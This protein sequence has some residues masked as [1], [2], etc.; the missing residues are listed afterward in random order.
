MLT[1]GDY[2][3][4]NCF[5]IEKGK[6][7]EYIIHTKNLL[8]FISLL[9]VIII[10][11]HLKNILLKR[12]NARYYSCINDYEHIIN[13]QGMKNHEYN[14]QLLVLKG[15]FDNKEKFNE[16]LDYIVGEYKTGQNYKVRQLFMF[17][18]CGIKELIYN[19]IFK[20]NDLEIKSHIYVTD[21]FCINF[22]SLDLDIN[23]DLSKILGVY[24]DNAIDESKKSLNKEVVLDFKTDSNY[25][26]IVIS[27]TYADDIDLKSLELN[28]FTTKGFGHGFGLQIVREIVK[29]NNRI[30]VMSE[31][32]GD[33][34][35][36]TIIIDMK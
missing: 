30:E 13:D 24:L 27:N 4:K 2:Y 26:I 20:M 31:I 3:K 16:Y 19:K 5:F 33:L 18:D 25:I 9:I 11:L 28:G 7:M 36:Q 17:P 29:N 10:Y 21:D 8:F 14:N 32:V 1:R 22:K 6:N 15:Y 23:K 34:F 35:S 12:K